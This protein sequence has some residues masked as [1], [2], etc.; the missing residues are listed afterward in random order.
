MP[1]RWPASFDGARRWRATAK[2]WR[3]EEEGEKCTVVGASVGEVDRVT[4]TRDHG[5]STGEAWGA[6]GASAMCAVSAGSVFLVL[7]VLK[8]RRLCLMRTM[9]NHV[10]RVRGRDPRTRYPRPP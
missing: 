4:G 5:A 3:D 2:R 8:E 10:G 6:Q 1:L 7:D 9:T